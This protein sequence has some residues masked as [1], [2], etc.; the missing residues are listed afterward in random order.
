[1]WTLVVDK[2]KRE[3]EVQKK[4]HQVSKLLH[5]R[6]KQDETRKNQAREE[7]TDENRETP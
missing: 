3:D 1:M 7:S 6:P 5:K 4:G 2:V